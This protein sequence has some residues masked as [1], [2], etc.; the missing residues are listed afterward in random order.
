MILVIHEKT[1]AFLVFLFGIFMFSDFKVNNT[2]ITFS[3]ENM[4]QK[5]ILTIFIK[6]LNQS[7]EEEFYFIRSRDNSTMKLFC[8]TNPLFF[9]KILQ[10]LEKTTELPLEKPQDS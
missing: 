5:D 2:N 10:E 1:N 7:F 8:S 3:A 4:D 6:K 9:S